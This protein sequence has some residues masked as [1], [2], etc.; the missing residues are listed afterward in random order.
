MM[1]WSVVSYSIAENSA[2]FRIDPQHYAN[3]TLKRHR[4]IS[5]KEHIV[6]D[7]HIQKIE[8]GRNLSQTNNGKNLFLRTQNIG[9]ILPNLNNISLTNETMDSCEGGDLLFVRVGGVGD[10][11][12]VTPQFEGYAFSDN[13]LRIKISFIDPFYCSV[14]FNTNF[15]RQYFKGYFKGTARSLIS[16]ANFQNLIVPQ[17]SDRFQQ[18]IRKLVLE[19]DD[20]TLCAFKFYHQTEKLLLSQLGLDDW[21]PNKKI[22]FVANYSETANANRID[23]DYFQPHYKKLLIKLDTHLTKLLSQIVDFDKGVEVGSSAY[24]AGGIPFIRVSDISENGFEKTEKHISKELY[25]ELKDSFSPKK[26]DVLF[27]KD[28]TIGRS[29]VVQKD[30]EAILSG[31]FLKLKIKPDANVKPDYLA[32]VLNSMIC[33]SQIERLSGG[34][35]IAH[36]RPDD[37]MGMTIPILGE[38]VQS[39]ICEMI[40]E[41]REQRAESKRLLDVAKRAV[42]IAIE[43]DE[44]IAFQFIEKETS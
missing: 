25:R 11:C 4:L 29:F 19:S 17:P 30:E 40:E 26:G 12:V 37:A 24:E 41:S 9:H 14:F 22:S 28:G 6:F 34:A 1:Q 38:D 10:N 5:K 2:D 27:T 32:L 18:Q 15:G 20:L 21:Q 43:Q 39:K 13:V 36:L 33:K 44:D 31:A 23:A 3:S 7:E 35:I 16:S 8:S 42:E